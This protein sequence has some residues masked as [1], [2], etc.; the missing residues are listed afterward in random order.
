MSHIRIALAVVSLTAAASLVALNPIASQAVSGS[1]HLCAGRTPTMVVDAHSAHVVHGTNGADVIQI[2][3]A[4]HVVLAG[5]GSDVVCGSAGADTVSGQG[6]ADLVLA[7]AGDDH[8]TGSAGAD[9]LSGEAGADTLIGGGGADQVNGGGGIDT[10]FGQGGN[11][12]LISSTWS[13]DLTGEA[14][15]DDCVTEDGA[16][17][18][19]DDA[20]PADA[21]ISVDT[22][23]WIQITLP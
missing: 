14:G 15:N 12:L 11:D 20:D 8:V 13:D 9:R 22:Q 4:G 1:S 6:G 7:G 5:Q 21:G 10:E 3:Q 17:T 18:T 2:E 23:V 16:V 19:C